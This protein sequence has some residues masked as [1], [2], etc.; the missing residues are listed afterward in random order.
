MKLREVR[1]LWWMIRSFRQRQRWSR[2]NSGASIIAFYNTGDGLFVDPYSLPADSYYCLP[3][4]WVR[5]AEYAVPRYILSSNRKIAGC[6]NDVVP[7][8]TLGHIGQH[9]RIRIGAFW[10]GRDWVIHYSVHMIPPLC[11]LY[12]S[13]R[14]GKVVDTL[15]VS[16]PLPIC[17][18][19]KI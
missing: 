1:P 10:D 18:M 3:W 5:F 8:Q 12:V 6:M 4:Q 14:Y 11:I 2:Q 9:A 13:V 17:L 7:F 19:N 16:Q 15:L